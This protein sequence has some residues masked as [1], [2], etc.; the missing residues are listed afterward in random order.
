ME[1]L[2]SAGQVL[3]GPAGSRVA[4]GAVLLRDNTIVAVGP[5]TEVRAQAGP[6]TRELAF[7]AGTV[8]PGLIDCHVHLAFD[9]SAKP[10]EALQE[11]DEFSLLLGMTGR[12]QQLLDCGVTTTRDLGDRDGLAVHLRDAIAQGSLAGPRI[13]SATAPLTVRGGH[14]WFMG[15]E[16]DDEDEIRTMVRRNARNGADL[17]KVMATGG[18]MTKGG[19]AIWEPQFSA[20][21]LKIVV[22]E[23]AEAGLRVAVHAHGVEGIANAVEAGVHTIEHCSWA[24]KDG[25]DLR[26]ELAEQIVAKGIFVCIGASPG[27]RRV[28]QVFGEERAAK[29]FGQ[30]RWMA[31]HGFRLIAGTDAGVPRAVFDNFASS[32]EFYAHIGLSNERVIETTTTEAAQALGIAE[33]TGQLTPGRDADVLVVDGDPLADL[34]ALHNVELVVAAGK[35]H[36]PNRT[37]AAR[38]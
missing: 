11:S 4:N 30:A 7:P 23:A 16:V 8:L 1:L 34:A 14:C 17:I 32:L 36:V 31:E 24:T 3:T 37:V 5:E 25:F 35:T 2:I 19:P 12:A 18:G 20:A 29:L 22:D 33:Q 38:S 28:P 21:E 13:L 9:A 15:G 26:P 10:V 27:W 6:E